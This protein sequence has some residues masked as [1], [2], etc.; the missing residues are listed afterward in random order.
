MQRRNVK[1]TILELDSYARLKKE[2]DRRYRR[3]PA[4]SGAS[5]YFRPGSPPPF[6]VNNTNFQFIT[7]TF[8]TM[9]DVYIGTL[10]ARKY[11]PYTEYFCL[12][13]DISLGRTKDGKQIYLP[14]SERKYNTQIIG[15]PNSGKSRL[16]AH[17]IQLLPS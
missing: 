6:D 15:L 5:F 11:Q 8:E 13:R 1:V 3:K 10:K 16:L 2:I 12:E 9:F 17:M 4:C 7:E 14:A